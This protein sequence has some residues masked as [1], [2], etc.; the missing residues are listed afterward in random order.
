MLLFLPTL[1]FANTNSIPLNQENCIDLEEI[2]KQINKSS[3]AVTGVDNSIDAVKKVNTVASL[4]N[5]IS[6]FLGEQIYCVKDEEAALQS[7]TLKSVGLFGVVNNGT[8]ALIGMYPDINVSD[9]LATMFVPGYKENNTTFAQTIIDPGDLELGGNGTAQND[10]KKR[11]TNIIE[12]A[13]KPEL[14]KT[15]QQ[16]SDSIKIEEINME[17][18]PTPSISGYNYLKDVVH[19]DKIW[20]SSL[21]IVYL[22]S[23]IIFIIVGF[24]IMFRK[25]LPG[26][27]TVTVS[28]ALPQIIISLV[29]ATFSFAIVGIIMD[30]GKVGINLSR[31]IISNIYVEMG[32]GEEKIIE[33]KNLWSLADDVF[34]KTRLDTDAGDALSKI[35][36]IGDTLA[37]V[38]VGKG[39]TLT[40]ELARVGAMGA[41]YYFLQKNLPEIVNEA[42][43]DASAVVGIDFGISATVD[44]VEPVLDFAQW[45]LKNLLYIGMTAASTGLMAIIIKSLIL[46]IICF[47]AAFKVFLTLLTTYLK[48]FINV[49]VAPFQLMLGAI[50][51]NGAQITNWLKSVVANTL[52][53]VGVFVVINIFT[54]ISTSIDPARFNFYGNDGVLW[55]DILV[56]L[57]SIIV[58]AGYLFAANLPKVI[59]NTL[60]VGNDKGMIAASESMKQTAKKI[61]LIGGMFN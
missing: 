46:I 39:N 30:L 43:V 57:Q 27:T 36:L 45:T 38:L 7:N 47:Y 48:L 11:T 60:G 14:E 40:G 34:Q 20:R 10:A 51:G 1:S 22:F 32:E 53:F 50:P 55:P 18:T 49:I 42:D 13:V 15:V 3:Q 31:S 21:N 6:L 23:I 8:N 54:L 12:K 28:K 59:N 19:L 29:L 5:V 25:N 44:I 61:P 35:P 16:Y 33:Q 56:S 52:V 41:T 26:N 37:G 2:Y 9:H 4:M 17:E 24:M 58:I